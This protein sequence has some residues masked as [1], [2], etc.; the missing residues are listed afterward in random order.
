[1]AKQDS[2]ILGG[3]NGKVGTVVGYRW[4]GKWCMRAYNRYVKN[5]RTAAQVEHREGF[6]QQVQLAAKMRMVIIRTL[7]DLAREAGMTSYNLFVKVNQPAFD[8]AEGR[9]A[10][11]YSALTLSLG[12]VPQVGPAVMSWTADN[13][14]ETRFERGVGQGFDEVRMYVYVP[15]LGEGYLT[16][17][18]HRCD[19]RIAVALPDHFA[20]REAQVYLMVQTTDGRWSDSQYVGAICLTENELP[21]RE[22]NNLNESNDNQNSPHSQ[23]SPTKKST[24]ESSVSGPARGGGGPRSRD[25]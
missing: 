25:R 16:A 23:N 11:D 15:E 22:I 24:P 3:Y 21:V 6:K 2:G 17:A 14:L 7:T 4:N 8:M 1:M 9:L 5:P 12:D 10:V 13:V 20:G 19:K 18:V